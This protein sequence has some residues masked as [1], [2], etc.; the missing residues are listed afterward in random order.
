MVRGLNC[1]SGK[2]ILK[3]VYWIDKEVSN[4]LPRSQLKKGDLVL[5]YVGTVGE[6]AIIDKDNTYHLAPNVAKISLYDKTTNNPIFWNYMLVLSRDY[7]LRHA[8]T[9]T[10]SSLSMEKIRKIPFII[11]DTGRPNE[12]AAFIEQLDKSKVELQRCIKSL[13]DTIKALMRILTTWQA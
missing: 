5:T 3:D 9:T 4:A 11:P 8:S 6:V 1:K 13:D 10:Q 12:F 2:L 7:I